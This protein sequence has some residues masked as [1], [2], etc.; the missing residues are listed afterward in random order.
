MYGLTGGRANSAYWEGLGR[1]FR[2][3]VKAFREVLSVAHKE[4][5][6]RSAI[7]T[8]LDQW[9]YLSEVSGG[10]RFDRRNVGGHA[11]LVDMST[12]IWPGM[13]NDDLESRNAYLGCPKRL[14]RYQ[15][16]G[17]IQRHTVAP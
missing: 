16:L 11:H 4:V 10:P 1:R 7:R 5:G 14:T 8:Y 3:T 13:N 6:M 15:S 12:G 2:Y 17:T 9:L